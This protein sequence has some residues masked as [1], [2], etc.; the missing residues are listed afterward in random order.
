MPPTAISP[1]L[2]QRDH[3][4]PPGQCHPLALRTSGQCRLATL[5][6]SFHPDLPH[7]A[8]HPHPPHPLFHSFFDTMPDS[9]H[10]PAR[11]RRPARTPFGRPTFAAVKPTPPPHHRTAPLCM[12]PHS[13]ITIPGLGGHQPS[14]RGTP[15]IPAPGPPIATRQARPSGIIWSAVRHPSVFDSDPTW[16]AL[17][18]SSTRL[19]RDLKI[20]CRHPF[21]ER[22]LPKRGLTR[23][24]SCGEHYERGI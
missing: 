14:H 21:Q 1:R 15:C 23:T 8:G 5:I 7:K 9:R 12:S 13:S 22:A 10:G 2:L 19:P 4:L 3:P 11:P 6:S 20:V 18:S 17:T 24:T 16:P